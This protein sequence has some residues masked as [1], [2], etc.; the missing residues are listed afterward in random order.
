MTRIAGEPPGPEGTTEHSPGIH[1]W[2][3][4]PQPTRKSRQGRLNPL[5]LNALRSL[6]PDPIPETRNPKP[7]IRNPVR[8]YVV[9]R[10]EQLVGGG[11]LSEWQ[12]VG[13]SLST[14]AHLIN[15]PRGQQIEYRVRAVNK[16]AEGTPSNTVMAVL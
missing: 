13:A 4:K 3:P 9:E 8:T 7:E 1:S 14:E 2:D 16:A 11:A 6:P 15:Q 5:P 12:Q 10:R